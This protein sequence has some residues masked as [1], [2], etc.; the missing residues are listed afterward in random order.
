MDRLPIDIVGIISTNLNNFRDMYSLKLVC[1]D[2]NLCIDKFSLIKMKLC[3]NLLLENKKKLKKCANNN[4]CKETK[5]VFLYEYAYY[6]KSKDSGITYIH[7]HQ[8]AMN[9][10]TIYINTKQYKIFSPY[11]CECLKENILVREIPKNKIF[12]HYCEGFVDIDYL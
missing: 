11:C 5:E 4:C 6:F 10:D 9:C 1:K 7:Y 8:P 3:K 2:Y 12:Q